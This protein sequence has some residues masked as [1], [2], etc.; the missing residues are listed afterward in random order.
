MRG[1]R[2]YHPDD[3]SA[4]IVPRVGLFKQKNRLL[5]GFQARL[6]APAHWR[7]ATDGPTSWHCCPPGAGRTETTR[8]PPRRNPEATISGVARNYDR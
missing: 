3:R 6:G 5:T 8:Y 7:S 4:A 1:F 2:L